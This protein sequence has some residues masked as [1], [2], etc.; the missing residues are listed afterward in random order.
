MAA[1]IEQFE[2]K[3]IELTAVLLQNSA[4]YWRNLPL[5][6]P[7]PEWAARLPAHG[8]EWAPAI[9]EAALRSGV[10]PRLFAALVW[11]ESY[12]HPGAV[13][14]AGALGLA[15]LMPGTAA[16]L[17]VDPYDPLQNLAGGARY[18]GVQLLRFGR[19]DLALAAY[20]AGP[21][22]VE[23]YGGVPPYAETQAYVL[24]VLGY[25]EALIAP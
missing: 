12:F 5:D 1:L 6:G 21:G 20:N 3:S 13:S 19:L 10:D 18:L 8:Q 17:G 25:Y 9:N 16:G 24:R 11:A 7:L 22:A 23:Q 4:D 14:R 2:T 15:Q